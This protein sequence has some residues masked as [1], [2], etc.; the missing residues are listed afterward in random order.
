MIIYELEC[1]GGH[2]FEGWFRGKEEL[3]SEKAAGRLSC[4]ACGDSEVRVLP[5]GGHVGRSRGETGS[6]PD[7]AAI[8][9]IL[10]QFLEKNF[11]NV[12][13]DFTEEALKMHFGE[14]D[15]RNIRGTATPDEEKELLQE[16]VEFVKFPVRKLQS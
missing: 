9:K 6:G 14:I 10:G 12:G 11:D 1:A 3:D 13:P 4:P 8:F 2:T 7:T 16:G 5:S 15:T